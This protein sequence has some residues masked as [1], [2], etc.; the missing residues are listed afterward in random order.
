M[1]L[2]RGR[3]GFCWRASGQ[4]DRLVKREDHRSAG[5]GQRRDRDEGEVHPG[6]IES[7]VRSANSPANGAGPRSRSRA[8]PL[9]RIAGADFY[10]VASQM[11]PSRKH[12]RAE[13]D[14]CRGAARSCGPRSGRETVEDVLI[15]LNFGGCLAHAIVAMSP[16]AIPAMPRGRPHGRRQH[17]DQARYSGRSRRRHPRSLARRWALNARFDPA[18]D[19]VIIDDVYFPLQIDPSVRDA[20]GNVT[21]GS[22][23]ILDAAPKTDSARSR[24]RRKVPHDEGL[25]RLEGVRAAQIRNTQTPQAAAR[26]VVSSAW[27]SCKGLFR[28]AWFLQDHPRGPK[29]GEQG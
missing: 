5:A 28:L 18:R 23:L 8:S 16:C 4:A 25:R 17:A 19:T 9:L 1:P 21:Q 20:R 7:K 29:E 12:D 10:G 22:K 6:E 13:P 11:P 15:D 26:K 27:D 24:C 14:E 3:D 2:G